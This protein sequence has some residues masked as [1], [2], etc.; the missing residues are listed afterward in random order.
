MSSFV[1]GGKRWTIRRDRR[2]AHPI[3]DRRL[4]RRFDLKHDEHA[5]DGFC[6]RRRREI[7]LATD[8]TG[9]RLEDAHFHELLHACWPKGVVGH[10]TEE[11]LI[12]AL[13]PRLLEALGS[14]KP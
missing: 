10:A 11:K 3:T 12:R 8:I 5:I 1:V 9:A 6:D 14:M 4:R 2:L 13:T 7:L